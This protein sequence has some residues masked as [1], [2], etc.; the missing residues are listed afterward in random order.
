MCRTCGEWPPVIARRCSTPEPLLAAAFERPAGFALKEP[1]HRS[2][3]RE[4]GVDLTNGALLMRSQLER[5][6]LA[7]ARREL[8][9]LAESGR[10]IRFPA[11][12]PPGQPD[13]KDEELVERQP[14]PAAF[15]L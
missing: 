11:A 7:I 4:I 9:R 8:A 13:L 1:F 12:P 10:L 5:K 2:R 15:G 3:L 6:P 14:P